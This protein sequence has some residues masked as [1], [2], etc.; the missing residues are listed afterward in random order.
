MRRL[1]AWMLTMLL[2]HPWIMIAIVIVIVSWVL[3]DRARSK[4]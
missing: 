4:R 1:P 3:I 2:H